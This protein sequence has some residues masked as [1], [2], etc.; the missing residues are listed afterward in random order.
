MMNRAIATLASLLLMSGPSAQ[1]SSPPSANETHDKL[2]LALALQKQCGG[3][4]LWEEILLSN[5]VGDSWYT[6]PDNTGSQA[7]VIARNRPK[8]AERAETIGCE[9]GLALRQEIRGM[10]A[11][12]VLALLRLAYELSQLPADHPSYRFATAQEVEL[13]AALWQQVNQ[14]Y[15]SQAEQLNQAVERNYGILV[16]S[17]PSGATQSIM[18]DRLLASLV[19]QNAAANGQI[20]I[21]LPLASETDSSFRAVDPATGKVW[22]ATDLPSAT[23]EGGV[24]KRERP[25]G[26]LLLGPDNNLAH[27]MIDLAAPQAL[28]KSFI[29]AMGGGYRK[30]ELA[31][32][33][34]VTLGCPWQ[35][36]Y[37]YSKA[38]TDRLLAAS[39]VFWLS[40]YLTNASGTNEYFVQSA[41]H[42]LK[43]LRENP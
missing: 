25:Y 7:E 41:Q 8:F 40:V 30:G 37:T 15:A 4:P 36:C 43:A 3:L 2:A 33:E 39:D 9:G 18:L 32:G 6:T 29:A 34:I 11:V 23:D 31:Q 12:D 27:I 10:V 42:E 26:L 20:E 1:A 16:A 17:D 28:P 19:L 5:A 38:D 35:A 14:E 21:Q 22:R 24:R 13:S